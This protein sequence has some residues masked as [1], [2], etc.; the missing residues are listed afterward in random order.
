[1]AGFQPSI[2]GRFWVSTEAEQRRRI[3]G[4]A[5]QILGADERRLLNTRVS[6]LSTVAARSQDDLQ[7]H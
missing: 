5:R 4:S 6:T 7:I 2:N 3:L 1:M